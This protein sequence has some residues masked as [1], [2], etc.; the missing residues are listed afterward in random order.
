MKRIGWQVYLGLFLVALSV[1]LY[2]FHYAVFGDAHH[3]FIYLV[4]DIAFVPVE[5]LLVTLIIHRLLGVREKRAMLYKLNMVIGAFF[6][7]VGTKLL[8]DLAQFDKDSESVRN[9]LVVSEEWTDETFRE[10][11]KRIKRHQPGIDIR[12]AD[13][14][15]LREF[16]RGKRDFLLRMLQNPNLLEHES[17]TDLLWATFHLAD[18]LAHRGDLKSLPDSDREHLEG[19]IKR[20]HDHLSSQW[21]DYMKHLKEHYPYLFSLAMRTNPFDPTA[22]PVVG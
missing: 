14:D 17:F 7:E 15:A 19:D 3:I 5:V 8:A 1:L 22:S 12:K 4:G 11:R 2:F 18:E 9:D 13:L 21:T 10:V 6:R 20:V 16:L